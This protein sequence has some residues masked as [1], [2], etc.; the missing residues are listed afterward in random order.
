MD[1]IAIDF[2]TANTFNGSA[3]SIGI[4]CVDG[5]M[6]GKEEYHLIKPPYAYF[7]KK[8]IEIHGITPEMV[9]DS[10]EFPGVWRSIAH[11]F[12]GS[13]LVIA[14][15]AQF[16]MSVLHQC[17]AAYNLPLP[18]F[19]Y[20]CSKELFKT[21]FPAVPNRS[22]VACTQYLGVKMGRHHNALDD[23]EACAE[24][25]LRI[26]KAIQKNSIKMWRTVKDRAAR[27]GEIKKIKESSFSEIVGRYCSLSIKQFS[28]LYA[29][30]H[31]G[32]SVNKD[33]VGYSE[34]TVTDDLR[35][36]SPFI[37]K[38]V[39]LSGWFKCFSKRELA[40]LLVN[41]GATVKPSISMKSDF[42]IVGQHEPGEIDD[43]GQCFKERKAIEYNG[44]G[45]N[46][47]IVHEPQL[48]RLLRKVQ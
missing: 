3:C 8:N 43:S 41:A 17:L 38:S 34:I 24:I 21:A 40:Q 32:D 2:E 16:D 35:F 44:K 19:K 10:S 13:S 22:L 7:A 30:R 26:E 12:D 36:G 39:V 20:T 11:Y 37:G 15:N 42:L 9:K 1:F 29:E 5:R 27:K 4:V 48:M 47:L 45:S 14:H 46:I 28:E 31:F 23:A 25:T 6:I 18:N 33:T